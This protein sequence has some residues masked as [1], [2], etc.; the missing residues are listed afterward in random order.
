VSWQDFV[1]EHGRYTR[2]EWLA[3]VLERPVAAIRNVR[4][5]GACK[6]LPKRLNF[7]EL[8]TRWHG[9]PPTDEEWPAPR[10][11]GGGYEWLTPEMALLARL[12]G[13]TGP[14][15]IC[16][17]LTERLRCLTGDAS[18]ERDRGA[19]QLAVARLGLQLGA[20]LVGGLTTREAAKRVGSLAVINQV[21]HNGTLRTIRVG[22]RHVIPQDEFE[23]WLSTRE[24]PPD[25]WVRLSPLRVPLGISSD[26]KLPEYASLG[27]IPDVR[28]VK[29]IGTA[30]GV[31]YIAPE[32]AQQIL[33]DASAG[34]PMPWHGKPLPVNQRQMWAKWQ[35]RRHRWC[36]TCTRI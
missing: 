33:A 17:I 1:L 9:R 21:I 15:D 32:R 13:T 3:R 31:W 16:R 22:K 4:H 2:V 36:R 26:A 7:G 18:A 35:A 8:F 28:L 14:G 20:D 5:T 23:R 10:K 6:R 27:Y 19:V 11:I 29:G 12:V 30:R 25:G 24:A 34:R